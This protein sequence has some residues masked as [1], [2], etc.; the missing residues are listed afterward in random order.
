MI[1]NLQS[2][3]DSFMAASDEFH[4][5]LAERTVAI[6]PKYWA[7]NI[8]IIERQEYSWVEVKFT[9]LEQHLVANPNSANGVG[10][11]LFIVKPDVTVFG[12]PGYVYYVGIAGENSSRRHLNMRL[13]EYLQFSSIKKRKAVHNALKFY[14]KNTYIVYSKV[15]LQPEELR[16]LETAFHG[17][18][19]PWAGKRDFPV[20]IKESRNAWGR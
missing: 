9:E 8:D 20:E 17:F 10:V 16:E 14:H 12:L 15:D 2:D 11:Y 4:L 5:K 18:Y 7:E 1:D 3:Y 19:Y 13:P 6:S